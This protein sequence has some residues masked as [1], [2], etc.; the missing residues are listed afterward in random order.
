MAGIVGIIVGMIES[1]CCVV[2]VVVCIFYGWLVVMFVSCSGDI[3]GVEDVLVDVFVMVLLIWFECGVFESFDVWFLIVVWC[4]FGYVCGCVVMVVVNEVMMILFDDECVG[5]GL[6]FFGDDWLK[7][8][9]VCV[10]FVIVVD[11]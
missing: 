10:Y 6:I 4:N 3:V 8:M 9:F 1:V 7:L 2:E 11:V 5:V